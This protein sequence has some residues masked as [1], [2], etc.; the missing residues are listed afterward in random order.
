LNLLIYKS[1]DNKTP[2]GKHA[3]ARARFPLAGGIRPRLGWVNSGG[4]QITTDACRPLKDHGISRMRY[5]DRCW[6]ARRLQ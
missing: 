2:A 5:Q 1:D 4:E 6:L 3:F